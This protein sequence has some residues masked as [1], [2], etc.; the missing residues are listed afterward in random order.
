M[1]IIEEE[2]SGYL[3]GQKSLDEV[4]TL[5]QSRVQIYVSERM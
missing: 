3:S 1:S 2:A 5:I 4:I